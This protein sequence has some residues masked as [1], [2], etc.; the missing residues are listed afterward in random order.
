M[1]KRGKKLRKLKLCLNELLY[2]HDLSI[3]QLHL[4]T[5]IRRATLSELANGKRQ[6][7]QF[8]HIEKIANALNIDDINDILRLERE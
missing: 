7:I 4:I 1:E 3:H 5:G 8:E 2:K 6:R